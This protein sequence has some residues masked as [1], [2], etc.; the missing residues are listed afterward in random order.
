MDEKRYRLDESDKEK[1]NRLR[2]HA[3][4]SKQAKKKL[5]IKG[6]SA[7]DP[8]SGLEEEYHVLDERG[9]HPYDVML[10]MT[11]IT[12]NTNSYYAMQIIE[13]D[14]KGVISE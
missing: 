1:Q 13:H 4:K 3:E 10:N 11:D 2:E 6:R 14:N 9:D 7:V 5:I 8:D 12:T